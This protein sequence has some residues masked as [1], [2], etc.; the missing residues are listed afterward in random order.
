MS[1]FS[2][3]R[4]HILFYAE[5]HR[6]GWKGLKVLSIWFFGSLVAAA[7]LSPLAYQFTLWWHAH[8]PSDLTVYLTE[9]PLP[10][11]FDRLRWLIALATFPWVVLQC[12]LASSRKLGLKSRLPFYH[13]FGW[14]FFL[15]VASIAGLVAVQQWVGASTFR[16]GLT[17]GFVLN[18][19]LISFLAALLVALGEE[20]VFRA[21]VLR[22][23]YTAF[24][25]VVSVVLSALFF[26]Y[27]H[28]DM[29]DHLWAAHNQSPEGPGMT[30]GFYV[31]FW[32]VFG[33]TR[34]FSPLLFLNLTLVGY[35]LTVVFM[36]TRS[37]WA[38]IGL[39]A[40]WVTLILSYSHLGET[41]LGDSSPWWGSHRLADGFLCLAFLL[42]TAWVVT[43]LKHPRARPWLKY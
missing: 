4:F 17:A 27:L 14:Y 11:Y 26:A 41:P 8:S 37:L 34:S 25:P 31:A 30:D 9:K 24:L 10:N 32:T 23:F 35:I 12:G 39:H 21:V 22:M 5:V 29:P 6:Y 33:I 42:S 13:Y 40:G 2:R 20:L 38:S 3:D 15:G 28:F 18:T 16:D 43:A 1:L 36:R 7:I 19:I